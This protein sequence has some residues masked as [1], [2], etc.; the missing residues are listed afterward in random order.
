MSR[1][2]EHIGAAGEFGLEKE[3]EG[4]RIALSAR[5]EVAVSALNAAANQAE[6]MA[7]SDALSQAT[8]VGDQPLHHTRPTCCLHDLAWQMTGQLSARLICK[9]LLALPAH[10]RYTPYTMQSHNY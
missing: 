7:F 9:Y 10:T 2:A 5:Q 6:A 8:E 3:A 4:C 1:N